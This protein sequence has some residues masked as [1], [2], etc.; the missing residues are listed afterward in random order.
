M[1][2]REGTRGKDTGARILVVEDDRSLREGLSMNFSLQGYRATTAKDGEEGLQRAFEENPDLIVL[3]VML[4]GMS[5][6][7]VLALL[8]ERG[9]TMPILV[10]S[11]RGKTGEKV[12]GLRLGADDYLGKPFELSELLARVEALLRR[13]RDVRATEAPIRFGEVELDPVRRRVRLG[14]EDVP[15]SSK[16]FD[17]LHLLARSPGRPFTREQ[18]LEQVWR[19]DFEGTPRT[20]DNFIRSLRQKVEADPTNPRHIKTVRQVGYKLDP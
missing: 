20:V 17:L 8:R 18:I 11:A 14:R 10:L 13:K 7:E 12:E 19:W 1:S 6:L 15:L 2:D 5:G 3:D 16:E 4:P 9:R